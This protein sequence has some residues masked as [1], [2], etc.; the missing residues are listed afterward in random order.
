M[1]NKLLF[2]AVVCFGSMAIA[3][4]TSEAGDCYYGRSHGHAYHSGYAYRAPVAV[5]RSY[6]RGYGVPS[7]RGIYPTYGPTSL[8]RSGYGSYIGPSARFG[9]GGYRGYGYPGYG[10]PYGRSGVSIGIGF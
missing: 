10:Y 2:A 9:Y 6:Y 3:D 1:I 7:Y 8:Y 4:S 5:S